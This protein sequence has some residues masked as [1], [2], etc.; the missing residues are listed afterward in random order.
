MLISRS[1]PEQNCAV[2]ILHENELHLSPLETVALL[3]PSFKYL[4]KGDKRV[5]SESKDAGDGDVSGEEEEETKQITVKFARQ[6]NERMKKAREKS[7]SYVN[8]MNAKE[9]WY[10]ANF[11]DKKSEKSEVSFIN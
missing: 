9:I 4:D 6:E 5:K 7:F 1:F 3:R 8:Q 11:Y 10:K 2:G